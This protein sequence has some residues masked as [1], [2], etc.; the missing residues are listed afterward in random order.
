MTDA[1]SQRTRVVVLISGT[2]SNLQALI[3]AQQAGELPIELVAVISNRP[4]AK[5]L[6]RAER[7][8]IPTCV[9]DHTQFDGRES[10]DQALQRKI[11]AYQPDLI[12]LAG[13]MRILTE[14]F[15][16]HYEGR[17]LNIHPSL[18]PKY[19][20][21]NTHERA[22]QAGDEE[23]GVTIHFVTAELDGGPIALQARVPVLP[24]D[25]ATSLA[26]RVLVQE[27]R[28]YPLAVKWFAEGRL[29]MVDGRVLLNSE[30]LGPSG[31]PID[32][33]TS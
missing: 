16:R 1:D 6:K 11:D 12:V 24:D 19:Q 7:A 18:L 17:M 10:F 25:D 23:H 31:Y 20:G 4:E 21:L 27:H 13:F 14:A 28:I 15:T 30:P 22:L 2:G 8:G 3:N 9:V 32:T 26:Q 5:G 33:H 29:R